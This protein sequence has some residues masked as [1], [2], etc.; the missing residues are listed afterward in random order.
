MKKHYNNSATDPD[1]IDP[2]D[3]I[4][5]L[6]EFQITPSSGFL[7]QLLHRIERHL[8]GVQLLDSIRICIRELF[9]EYWHLAISAFTGKKR[10][11]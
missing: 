2:G 9:I 4:R 3:P 7:E 6:G 5:E 10:K 8:L 11:S 1:D